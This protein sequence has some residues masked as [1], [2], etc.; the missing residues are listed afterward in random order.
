MC[1]RTP[2][3]RRGQLPRLFKALPPTFTARGLVYARTYRTV[4]CDE[5]GDRWQVRGYRNMTDSWWAFLL[6]HSA[7]H[8]RGRAAETAAGGGASSSQQ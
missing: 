5:C 6:Q 4:T 8:A 1:A 3:N 2:V 7:A